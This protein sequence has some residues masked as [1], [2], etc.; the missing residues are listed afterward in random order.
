MVILKDNVRELDVPIIFTREAHDSHNRTTY[1]YL[2]TAAHIKLWDNGPYKDMWLSMMVGT[3]GQPYEHVEGNSKTTRFQ[4][5]LRI[6]WHHSLEN[7]E[8]IEDFHFRDYEGLDVTVDEDE[9]ILTEKEAVELIASGKT[10][11]LDEK[12]AKRTFYT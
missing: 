1:V 8:E 3:S 2:Q 9:K 4:K 5:M 6:Y 12:F 11:F 10:K 7:V